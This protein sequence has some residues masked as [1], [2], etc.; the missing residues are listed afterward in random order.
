MKRV[1]AAAVAAAALLT[2]APAQAA[3]PDPVKALKKQLVPGHGVK[4]SELSR[5]MG[6]G[7][8]PTALRV[9]GTF[10]FGASGVVASDVILRGSFLKPSEKIDFRA[11]TVG[12]QA[13]VQSEALTKTLPEGKTWLLMG[14]ASRASGTFHPLDI[15]QPAQ[16]KGLL[17]HAKSSTGRLYR[18]TLTTK[19]TAKLRGLYFGPSVDYRLSVDSTG[20]P[21]RFF[22]G[23][24]SSSSSETVDTRYSD[25]GHKVTIKAPPEE[26]VI[27]SEELNRQALDEMLQEL[28][29]FQ[30][31][32]NE[33]LASR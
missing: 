24:K 9:T 5:S 31:I 3:T 8:K 26:L 32:P 18:G 20:L 4:V 12:N 16:L 33:A 25:W 6:K 23:V 30:L 29:E 14:D 11:V 15:F 22:T 28:Q 2:A 21:S 19:Q 7:K 1:L 10:E 27:S 17:S 13:Y